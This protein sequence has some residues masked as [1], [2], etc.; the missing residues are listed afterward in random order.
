MLDKQTMIW[1]HPRLVLSQ[2]L[3]GYG[4]CSRIKS[5]LFTVFIVAIADDTNV[6]SKRKNLN[7]LAHKKN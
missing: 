7:T 2:S 3:Q 1:N 6:A 4:S 5:K